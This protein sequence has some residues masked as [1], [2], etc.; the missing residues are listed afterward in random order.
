MTI[1]DIRREALSLPMD[2]RAL[3]AEQ[4]LSSLDA[5]S[6][7]ESTR[8]WQDEAER[9]AA[10]IDRGEI[11]LVSADDFERQVEQLFK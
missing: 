2:Q 9:R 1:E 10:E 3:L 7:A 5:L 4:L 6:E 8:L 11:E